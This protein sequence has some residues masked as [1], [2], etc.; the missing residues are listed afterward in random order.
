MCHRSTLIGKEINVYNR[1][2][3]NVCYF[4]EYKKNVNLKIY[5]IFSNLKP[6]SISMSTQDV[7]DML[8]LPFQGDLKKS[9]MA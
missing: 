6:V 2:V 5:K 3:L 8:S 4:N 9:F 7:R 1:L